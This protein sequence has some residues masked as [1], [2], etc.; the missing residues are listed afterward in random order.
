MASGRIGRFAG[1]S[2]VAWLS[3][4]GVMGVMAGVRWNTPGFR[5]VDIDSPVEMALTLALVT[6]IPFALVTIGLLAPC[7]VAADSW[8]RGRFTR[9][10]NAM[11]GASFGLPA[12]AVFLLVFWS[13]F[14]R[15]RTFGEWL[16]AF[17]GGPGQLVGFLVI[18]M[19]GGIVLSLGMRRRG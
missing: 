10:V 2:V 15:R 13:L 18:F 5:D 3:M 16:G 8:L 7:T 17:N 9:R 1:L 19:I 4:V 14:E 6:A 12:L 11:V